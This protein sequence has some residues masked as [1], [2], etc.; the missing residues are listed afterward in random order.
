MRGAIAAGHPLTVAAGARVL[1]DG[2]NAVDAAVGAAFVAWVAE[3]PLTGP[4]AGG[5]MLVHRARDAS[6]RVLDFFVAAP[7]RGLEGEAAPMESVDVRF[8]NR[9]VQTFLIGPASCAVPGMAAGLAE[10][11]RLYGS[12]PWRNLVEPA[13]ELAREGVA[14]T[15]RQAYLH[16]IL[17]PILRRDAE[18]RAI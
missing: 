12:L 18:G 4:G 5:F 10:A 6:Q 13:I 14:L 16:A 3:S 7:G 2:G 9:T 11:H 1:A 17:D 8:D 15:T